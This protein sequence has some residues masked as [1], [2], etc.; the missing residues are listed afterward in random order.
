MCITM[1]VLSFFRVSIPKSVCNECDENKINELLNK[2]NFKM[3]KIY[4]LFHWI[5]SLIYVYNKF[6]TNVTVK[7]TAEL[8]LN[9]HF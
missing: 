8:C 5:K 7:D 2:E 3:K 9:W 6:M 4:S 1:V